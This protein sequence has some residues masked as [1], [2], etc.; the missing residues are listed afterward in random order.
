MQ[1]LCKVDTLVKDFSDLKFDVKNENKKI[2]FDL[3]YWHKVVMGGRDG[4]STAC[5]FLMG[6]KEKTSE[7]LFAPTSVRS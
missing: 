7:G 4:V 6:Q 2:K 3:K 5:L 1:C